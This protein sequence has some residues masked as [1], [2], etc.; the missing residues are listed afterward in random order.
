MPDPTPSEIER[1]R[2]LLEKAITSQLSARH[3]AFGVPWR[4]MTSCVLDVVIDALARRDAEV[5]RLKG[6]GAR[7]VTLH[8]K[9]TVRAIS[10][11]VYETLAHFDLSPGDEHEALC[12]TL[13]DQCVGFVMDDP[14]G[15]AEHIRVLD[16][17]DET[18]AR[19]TADLDA[20]RE[21]LLAQEEA[22]QVALAAGDRLTA[23]RDEA[24]A[25]S[26]HLSQRICDEC[27]DADGYPTGWG[28]NRV[29]GRFACVCM[30]E[31]EPYQEMQKRAEAAEARVR[32]LL[33]IRTAAA[34]HLEF[35]EPDSLLDQET[36]PILRHEA[37]L[38][39]STLRALIALR[40]QSALAKGADG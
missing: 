10:E 27:P 28:E 17:R 24:R 7:D 20:A 1:L 9:H 26:E 19:L 31:A 33:E 29:E 25:E 32:E 38:A 21:N 2:G 8:R 23:E 15:I 39:V 6:A 35:L 18:I 13:V 3:L 22:T 37:E 14:D 34:A 40:D 16:L 30:A 5:E 12:A 4:R 11:I 36:D